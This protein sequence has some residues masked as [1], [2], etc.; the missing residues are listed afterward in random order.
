MRLQR[1]AGTRWGKCSKAELAFRSWPAFRKPGARTR[2]EARQLQSEA[3]QPSSGSHA[4]RRSHHPAG[5][6]ARAPN[7]SGQ[8]EGT[9]PDQR[10]GDGILSGSPE[11]SL[12]SE[13]LGKAVSE[14]DA[15][16]GYM[17]FMG[18]GAENVEAIASQVEPAGVT[19]PPRGRAPACD[20]GWDQSRRCRR[21][22]RRLFRRP[23]G[24]GC[25]AVRHGGGWRD[26]HHG[27]G[28]PTRRHSRRIHVQRG[29]D[30]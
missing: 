14:G 21:R 6:P 7:P 25:T 13:S 16:R 27:S 24:R 2:D 17:K 22:G 15:V 23:R 18:Q 30:A 8:D 10:A 1:P 4:G 19:A 26:P 20:P 9:I 11:E 5:R 28:S 12:I 29:G 3:E